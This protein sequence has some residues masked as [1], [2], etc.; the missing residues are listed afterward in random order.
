MSAADPLQ[1]FRQAAAEGRIALATSAATHAVLPLLATRAGLRLQIDTGIRSHRRRFGWS[2]GFWLPECAYATGARVATGRARRQLVLRRSECLRDPAPDPFCP[3][4]T[5]AGPVAL[6]IDWE[7]V[8]WLWS[9][10][11]YPSDPAHAQF[12]GK[13]AARGADLAGRGRGI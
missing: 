10:D 13:V 4:A 6:P 7:A 11:G 9:L 3:I 2:G 12:A 8:G 5:E 1:S